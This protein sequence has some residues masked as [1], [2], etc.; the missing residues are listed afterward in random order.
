MTIKDT[1]VSVDLDYWCPSSWE[2]RPKI[3]FSTFLKSIPNNIET[4]TTIEHHQVLRPLRKAIKNK[5][6]SIPLNIIHIDTHHDYYFNSARGKKIDCGNFMWSIPKKW[7]KLFKWHQPYYP[8]E[9]DWERVKDKLGDKVTIS[10]KKPKINWS[11]VGL[12]TFTLS[13]DYCEELIYKAER[14]IK[15]ITKKFNLNRTIEKRGAEQK[16]YWSIASVN[17]WGYKLLRG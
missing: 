8:E 12:I 15:T 2:G 1:W 11:R 17:S 13:P 16:E 6:L 7:Y 9:W 5:I 10:N 4:H 3:G 14:I